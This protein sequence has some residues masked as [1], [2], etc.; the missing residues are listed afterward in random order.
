MEI[1]LKVWCKGTHLTNKN[2]QKADWWNVYDFIL[3][4]YYNILHIIGKKED[5]FFEHFV[6]LQFTGLYDKEGT[7]IY[8]DDLLEVNYKGKLVQFRVYGVVGGFAIKSLGYWKDISD[9]KRGDELI[10][11]YL[12]NLQNISWIKDNC[13]V[14]KN[15]NEL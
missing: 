1:K 15:N 10:L 14:V 4:K 8:E 12:A 13:T 11:D 7:E 2:F 3:N 6:L 9:L 5:E